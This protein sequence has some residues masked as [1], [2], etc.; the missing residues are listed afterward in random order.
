[1]ASA[2]VIFQQNSD[3]YAISCSRDDLVL[4]LPV[5]VLNADN[6]GAVSWLWVLVDKPSGSTAT[7]ASPTSSTTTFTPD[8]EGTYLVKL[9]VNA[10]ITDQK[11][12]GIKTANL[13]YRIP[14]ATETTEFDGYR[15]WA[16]AVNYALKVLDDGYYSPTANTLQTAYEADTGSITLNSINGGFQIHDANTPITDSL[17]EVDAYGNGTKYF[18]VDPAA[19]TFVGEIR[20]TGGLVGFGT[21]TPGAGYTNLATDLSVHIFKSGHNMVLIDNTTANSDSG[22][23]LYTAS[24]NK[25]VV[26]IDE[27]DS[28]KLK[29]ALGTVDTDATRVS[30]TKVT[31]QQDGAVGIGTTSPSAKL[32][33][34]GTGLFTGLVTLS[35]GFTAGAGSSMGGFILGSVGTPL[36]GTDAANKDYVDGLIGTS[37][38]LSGSLTTTRIPYAT[39]P[40]TL[41]DSA[42]LTWDNSNSIAKISNVWIGNRLI[43]SDDDAQSLS[44]L[45]GQNGGLDAGGEI[46]LGGGGRVDGYISI[47]Q[48]KQNGIEIARFQGDDAYSNAGSLGIGT[49]DPRYTIDVIGTGHIDTSL[50]VGN[51]P[52]NNPSVQLLITNQNSDPYIG[53]QGHTSTAPNPGLLFFD[54]TATSPSSAKA[55]IMANISDGSLYIDYTGDFEIR[56]A[57]GSDTIVSTDNSG[58][59]SFTFPIIV[60]GYEIDPGYTVPQTGEVLTYNGTAFVPQASGI[61]VSEEADIY[62]QQLT[63]TNPTIVTSHTPGTNGNYVVYIYYRVTTAST[64]ITID[65]DWTDQTGSQTLNLL[66]L[67]TKP[68]GSYS[69]AGV[70]IQASSGNPITVTFTA[71]TA[72]QVFVS[73]T[74]VSV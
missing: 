65:I 47:I 26:F 15:G 27:S 73:S 9:V 13:A 70:Y 41:S 64:D 68:V 16:V 24:S 67:T 12:A 35:A 11:G 40:A 2:A 51:I 56:K 20:Q 66:P 50:L 43:G 22:L 59:V 23:V 49:V 39:G 30:N 19:S 7:L 42:N 31:I 33:T 60:D 28:Q 38:N 55:Q 62:D 34:A 5:T 29:F 63:T 4:N 6:T 18:K 54:A 10:S 8:I 53:L 61:T 21:A 57:I 58:Y 45:G 52:T 74:I 72:N 44:I 37:G 14:A 17:F 32:H 3:G 25:A 36:S 1:M 69:V 48:F 71:G 46:Y